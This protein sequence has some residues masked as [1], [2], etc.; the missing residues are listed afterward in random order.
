MLKKASRVHA[1]LHHACSIDLKFEHYYDIIEIID[2]DDDENWG[3]DHEVR[4]L[5]SNTNAT[6]T[7][8]GFD[9]E[10]YRVK[11]YIAENYHGDI[12]YV[13]LTDMPFT[14]LAI[15]LFYDKED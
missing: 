13:G 15:T 9:L 14:Q 11:H 1:R 7:G 2:S 12:I 4:V 8:F 3:G 6:N 5:F 10:F